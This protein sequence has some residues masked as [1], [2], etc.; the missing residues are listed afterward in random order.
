MKNGGYF[1]ELKLAEEPGEEPGE[2]RV[3]FV[4][5]PEFRVFVP[6]EIRDFLCKQ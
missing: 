3:R 6:K 1:G 2:K 4:K 5:I